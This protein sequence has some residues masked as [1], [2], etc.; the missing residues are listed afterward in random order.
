M[1]V[2]SGFSQPVTGA[3]DAYTAAAAEFE[4]IFLEHHAGVLRVLMRLVG[5][6][7]AEELANEVFFR[8]SRRSAEWLLTANVAGWLYRTATRAGIDALRSSSHRKRYEGAAAREIQQNEPGPMPDLLREEDCKRVRGVLSA[9]KPARA[10]I[11]LMRASGASYR[12]IAAALDV[13]VGG[14]GTLLNRAEEDFRKRFLKLAGGNEG[15]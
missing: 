11:L 12:E 6:G 8:L 5:P 1:S 13:A 2:T 3:A 10:Q 14:V 15:L 7:E 9:M 4:L